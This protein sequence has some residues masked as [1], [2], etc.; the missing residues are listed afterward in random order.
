VKRERETF[1]YPFEHLC[2]DR[3]GLSIA[4]WCLASGFGNT[5]RIR[6][7]RIRICHINE[8]VN[9]F[10]ANLAKKANVGVAEIEANFFKNERPGS[11][12]LRFA[13][14]EEVANLILY[15]SSPLSSATNGASI[16]VDGGVVRS[17]L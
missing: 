9:K 13:T 10:I 15:Y 4:N 17:I 3:F 16:R 11:L 1:R 8:G 12:L 7:R 5:S 2:G 6:N 14:V